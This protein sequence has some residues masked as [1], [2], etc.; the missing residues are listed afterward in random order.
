[1]VKMQDFK[2]HWTYRSHCHPIKK[3]SGQQHNRNHSTP[4]CSFVLIFAMPSRS[5]KTSQS[6]DTGLF[7]DSSV[8]FDI[9]V[10]TIGNYHFHPHRHHH[11][12]YSHP[13][14]VIACFFVLM[15]ILTSHDKS[16]MVVS[17]NRGSRQSSVFIGFSRINH[18]FWGY[19][20]LWKPSTLAPRN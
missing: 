8:H 12:N 2:M 17:K 9:T 5:R 11:H 3:V 7:D 19:R 20:H 13:V 15:M 16:H 4:T 18:A 1:M 14:R 6:L 10:I